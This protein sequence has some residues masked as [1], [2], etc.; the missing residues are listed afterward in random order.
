M[1]SNFLV[2]VSTVLS[3]IVVAAPASSKLCEGILGAT[4]FVTNK[5]ENTIIV[6]SIGQDG[7]LSFA[8]EVPTGGAGG[9]ASGGP[10]ALFAQGTII[11]HGRVRPRF[12]I[13]F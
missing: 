4:Y 11:Q 10:D 3:S 1:R 8:R 12:S 2:I 13:R 9:S 7:T 5:N 6:S